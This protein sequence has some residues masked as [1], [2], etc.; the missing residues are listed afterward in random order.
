MR[1][2]LNPFFSSI[3]R[4]PVSPLTASVADHLGARVLSMRRSIRTGVLI[5]VLLSG[6]AAYLAANAIAAPG[7]TDPG[8]VSTGPSAQ[9][10]QPEAPAALE[11]PDCVLQ[12]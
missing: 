9:L 12:E 6:L 1:R 8:E 11:R 3:W 7:Q 4:L 10:A 2:S 5:S